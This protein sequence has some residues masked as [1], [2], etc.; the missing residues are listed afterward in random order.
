MII[1]LIT[2]SSENKDMDGIQEAIVELIAPGK[3]LE[4]LA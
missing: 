3:I 1:H 4:H 2:Q